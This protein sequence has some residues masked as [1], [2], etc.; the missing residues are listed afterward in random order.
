MTIFDIQRFSLHDGP[1]IRTTVFLKGC[2]LRCLWCQNPEGL[3][4][5][6]ADVQKSKKA[7]KCRCIAPE[8]LAE[9]VQADS[10]FFEVSGGGV[11]FSGGEALA[12]IDDVCTAADILRTK[13]IHT[14]LETSLYAPR[15]SIQKAVDSID[16]ILADIKIFDTEKHKAAIGADNELIRENFKYAAEK[17]KGTGRLIARTPLIPGYTADEKNI[18]EIGTFI[19]SIDSSIRWELLNFNPLASAKYNELHNSGFKR[20]EGLKPFSDSQMNEFKKIAVSC[21][22]SII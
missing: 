21:G 17:L 20:F 12:Q 19:G 22:V 2:P 18:I 13:K 11:T 4:F 1:G 16:L 15:E 7:K 10:V 6:I 9:E 8:A 14:A 5:G 3:E